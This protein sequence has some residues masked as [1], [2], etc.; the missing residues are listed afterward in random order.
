MVFK[1]FLVEV[2]FNIFFLKHDFETS[3]AISTN[4][5]I[6]FQ[7]QMNT[8]T[9][10]Q[11]VNQNSPNLQTLPANQH[12]FQQQQ[13]QQQPQ[14]Q[15]PQQL[16]Q[17]HQIQNQNQTYISATTIQQ[18]NIQLQSPLSTGQNIG[19]GFNPQQQQQQQQQV[20]YKQMQQQQINVQALQGGQGQNIQHQV[21]P[22]YDEFYII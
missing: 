5:N 13:Q 10:I 3:N 2:I 6:S 14:Q 20:Q 15:Q 4:S 8:A 18:Q 1:K 11:I 16:P 17:T 22:I 9:N 19:E 12:Q 7:S 21:T